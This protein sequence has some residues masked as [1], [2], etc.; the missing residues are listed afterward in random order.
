[1]QKSLFLRIQTDTTLQYFVGVY[2]RWAEPGS[3]ERG[4]SHA[5]SG[6]KHLVPGLTGIT[7]TPPCSTR[8]SLGPFEPWFLE[9]T[10]FNMN[11]FRVLPS[12]TST[13]QKHGIK[14]SKA[15]SWTRATHWRS[16]IRQGW[17]QAE[18]SSCLMCQDARTRRLDFASETSNHSQLS[19]ENAWE[20]YANS[21]RNRSTSQRSQNCIW[22]P[23]HTDSAA[24]T[25]DVI[26][27]AI[28]KWAQDVHTCAVTKPNS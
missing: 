17:A 11:V 15:S 22:W 2:Q 27:A 16:G 28:L 6:S 5:A 23:R 7:T 12:P 4:Q 14:K 21:F 24:G 18:A 19:S 20:G 3:A 9:H 25:W 8:V 10:H 13:T 26:D 1:M